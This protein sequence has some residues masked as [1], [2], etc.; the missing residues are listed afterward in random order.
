[1]A[2]PLPCRDTMI[3]VSVPIGTQAEGD[4]LYRLVAQEYS[5]LYYYYGSHFGTKHCGE[6]CGIVK[7]GSVYKK[8]NHTCV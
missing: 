4:S 3:Y 5:L 7:D 6:L 8:R 1:M 2:T